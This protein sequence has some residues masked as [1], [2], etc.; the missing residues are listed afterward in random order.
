MKKKRKA[1][2]LLLSLCM[3]TSMCSPAL[4]E[5]LS[6]EMEI[7]DEQIEY[8]E[9]IQQEQQKR[10]EQIDETVTEEEQEVISNKET[11]NEEIRDEEQNITPSE[12]VSKEEDSNDEQEIISNEDINNKTDTNVEQKVIPN[13]NDEDV[14]LEENENQETTPNEEKENTE[15]NKDD[16]EEISKEENDNEENTEENI[17]EEE[18][19]QEKEEE[20][21]TASKDVASGTC[22][23]NLTWTLENGT[24]TISGTG[25]MS[26]NYNTYDHY[27]PWHTYTINEVI[28]S[29]GV[30]SIANYAFWRTDYLRYVTIPKSVVSIGNFAFENCINLESVVIPDGVVNI[31]GGAFSRC[32]NLHSITIPDSVNNIGGG[33][34]SSTGL[35]SIIIPNGVTSIKRDTFSFCSVLPSITIP[36]SVIS[37][38]ESA[39]EHC[40]RL[41]SI[42][43]PDSVTSIGDYA[44]ADCSNLSSIR[45]PDSV[46]SIGKYIFGTSDEYYHG[47][48]LNLTDI[49]YGGSEDQWKTLINSNNPLPDSV[50]VH[51]NSTEPDDP[52]PDNPE[53]L[54]GFVNLLTEW[55]ESTREVKFGNTFITLTRYFIAED[56]VLP[57]DNLTD[58]IDKYIWVETEPG[59]TESETKVI[60][61]QA[62]DSKLGTLTAA[63]KS[64]VTIDGTT[65]PF[66]GSNP[67]L[68]ISEPYD[69]LYHKIGDTVV[70]VQSLS[71]KTGTLEEWDGTK[72][73]VTIGREVFDTNYVTDM[74]FLGNLSQIIGS[75]VDYLLLDN[76]VFRIT[77]VGDKE[78]ASGKCGDNLTWTIKDGTLTISGTG[79]MYDY[80]EMENATT[81]A[82]WEKHYEEISKIVITDEVTSIGDYAFYCLTYTKSISIGKD[83]KRVGKST[84]EATASKI[85]FNGKAP[86]EID[87]SAFGA[88][89][90]SKP[91]EIY[92]NYDSD[93]QGWNNVIAK[94]YANSFLSW[95]YSGDASDKLAVEDMW[96][97][98]NDFCKE[99]DGYYITSDDFD[100]L[101]KNLSWTEKIHI[102]YDNP[103]EVKNKIIWN[104]GSALLDLLQKKD[105]LLYN[106]D[107]N[108]ENHT[109]WG[110]SCRGMSAI[111]A[112]V[113]SN[114]I[115]T[116][117]LDNSKTTLSEVPINLHIQSIINFYQMQQKIPT[118]ADLQAAF[119]KQ[120]Q[121]DQIK[122]ME[123]I[124]HFAE[125][126]KTAAL[127]S[128]KYYDSS[129][130]DDGSHAILGYAIENGRFHFN[131]GGIDYQFD[132]RV[133]TYDPNSSGKNQNRY[134]YSIYYNDTTWAIPGYSI[135]GVVSKDN[136]FDKD[137]NDNTAQFRIVIADTNFIN[138]VDYRT[139]KKNFNSVQKNAYLYTNSK[140]RFAVN[141]PNGVDSVQNGLF[142]GRNTISDNGG[143][144]L[145]DAANSDFNENQSYS[146]AYSDLD[147]DYEIVS[148]EEPISFSLGYE[149][150]YLSANSDQPGNVKFSPNGKVELTAKE[151]SSSSLSITANDGY[152][153]LPW[154]TISIENPDTKEISLELNKDGVLL[155]GD[156]LTN[157]TIYGT[158]EEETQ[159]LKFSTEENKVLVSE[160]KEE[161]VILEDSNKDGI[162]DKVVY[163]TEKPK[164]EEPDD[165]NK[166]DE[167]SKPSTPEEP[168][169]PNKP[170]KPVTPNKPNVPTTPDNPTTPE[171]QFTITFSGNGGRIDDETLKTILTSK[172]GKITSL[173][174]PVRTGYTFDG[175]FTERYDGE[176]ITA[177]T[178]FTQDTTVYAQWTNNSSNN[179]SS[180]SSSG[181]SSSHRGS[182]S[183]SSKSIASDQKAKVS[184]TAGGTVIANND[185]T[186][187]ITPN[188]G[189][190][191]F[192]ISINGEKAD[193]PSDGKLTNLKS[194]DT[195]MV[196]FDPISEIIATSAPSN[197]SNKFE[198]VLPNAWYYEAVN[199]VVAHNLF[200]GMSVTKF[201]PNDT[202][203]RA[204]LMT[205]LAR[206]DGQDVTGGSTWYEKGMNWAKQ[207]Q[208]SDGTNP[209]SD[210][211]REQLAAM[212]YRYAGYPATTGNLSQF[213][214]NKQTSNYAKSA[215]CW[216]TEKGIISG[217][218]NNILDPKGKATRAEVAAMLMKFCE[219]R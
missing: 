105:K 19:K 121:E 114:I 21:T 100:K 30:N 41:T 200:S 141:T 123:E 149:N 170:N 193:I 26:D 174:V 185:G 36:N 5:E 203:T 177:E 23:E 125:E 146:I 91:T 191:V 61:I 45:I 8:I 179:S 139:G 53:A 34:F 85:V 35:T 178:V 189:Y 74:S 12:E 135:D 17:F 190:K 182:S 210:I 59:A 153:P 13:E 111:V 132:H 167:P 64:N 102:I 93:K 160:E 71:K 201:A 171:Q 157:I 50:T 218:G 116:S 176:E 56:A 155:E 130:S 164:P 206:M 80:E 73:Q 52:N 9:D 162:F 152:H 127:I 110:G 172:D 79:D 37:I 82:P 94:Q 75:K 66:I 120:D 140:K 207:K 213:S 1:L 181:G 134:N 62:L 119:M 33:A 78:I 118:I 31:G 49:Y 89:E 112:L 2:S 4:A 96:S 6:N 70:S 128:F 163:P 205:V 204:M 154:H 197:N 29:D 211:T 55:N 183:S 113:K 133:L 39:F 137:S 158:D 117:E 147:S 44:F 122:K 142:N 144:I 169:K 68:F 88:T 92:C 124:I 69:I 166:P 215:L 22:G 131:I 208:I 168:S 25:D 145:V 186:A 48:C 136:N 138:A 20:I 51:Y 95:I 209:Q 148:E 115:A 27:T 43:I 57:S 173:P 196:R 150:Y 109:N 32:Y 161:L 97:F 180:S 14:K 40:S 214:D 194:E 81:S 198:D 83:I 47:E 217:K 84:F 86:N 151:D 90:G 175:W 77:P 98:A 126:H 219:M 24:L 87:I 63:S 195:V 38:E 42:E 101:L 11:I 159:E 15:S 202:M 107:G 143:V 18:D 60:R 67:P 212:L 104:V 58:F 188:D 216:A 65:Y 156:D 103:S 187:T 99:E 72:N 28:I 106:I 3:V 16:S 165:P 192:A 7:L 129:K 10:Q 108:I 54:N 184:C 199:Y 76:V 46:T